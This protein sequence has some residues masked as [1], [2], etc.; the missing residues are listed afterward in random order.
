M[1]IITDK[2]ETNKNPYGMAGF[3][4]VFSIGEGDRL[5]PSALT[6]PKL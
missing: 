1:N 2:G 5:V 4:D 6:E 3:Y